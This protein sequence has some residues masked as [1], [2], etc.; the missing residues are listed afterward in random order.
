MALSYWNMTPLLEKP[1][2]L[3]YSFSRLT[4]FAGHL[5]LVNLPAE[6]TPGHNTAPA[7]LHVR[8]EA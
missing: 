2:Q 1:G 7:E 3:H 4:K 5:T 6:A 8:C